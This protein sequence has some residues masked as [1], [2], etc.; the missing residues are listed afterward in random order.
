MRM[1][2]EAL[3]GS[4][5]Y[6]AIASALVVTLLMM[7]IHMVGLV[8]VDRAIRDGWTVTAIG[9][10][11]TLVGETAAHVQL[12][13]IGADY[14]AAMET[15]GVL[16]VAWGVARATQAPAAHPGEVGADASS[17]R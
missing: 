5:E 15:V 1:A 3:V 14:G 2:L 17:P 7:Y 10:A 13:R 8:P 9:L 12:L 16:L 6:A 11:V 4:I